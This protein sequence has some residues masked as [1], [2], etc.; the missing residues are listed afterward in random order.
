MTYKTT[1]KINKPL[2]EVYEAISNPDLV[3]KWLGGLQ[4]LETI[5]GIPGQE[6]YKSKYT[7]VENGRTAIFHEELVKVEPYDHFTFVLTGNGLVMEGH[8]TLSSEG[9]N[10]ILECTTKVQAQS[11][12]MRIMLLF[13]KG[14][15]S[16]RQK[17][18]FGRFK[19]MLEGGLDSVQTNSI[20]GGAIPWVD[21]N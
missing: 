14:M 16:K 4:K 9:S 12:G 21:P 1:T 11:F 20:K 18:D 13:A 6:G 8:T 3:P 15:M 7:F 17:Q 10:T 2:K 19:T 5:S